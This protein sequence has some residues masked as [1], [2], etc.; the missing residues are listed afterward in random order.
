[1]AVNTIPF[2]FYFCHYSILY[3][4]VLWGIAFFAWFFM[5][6]I[7]GESIA[8]MMLKANTRLRLE[9]RNR[10]ST[11]FSYAYTTAK[12]E[13][14]IIS[15][16]VQL[17]IYEATIID[18]Y[19][20]GRNSLCLSSAALNLSE[21][22]LIT[23]CLMKFAQFAHHDSEILA[24]LTAGNIWYIIMAVFCKGVICFWGIIIAIIFFCMGKGMYGVI[25]HNVIRAMAKKTEQIILLFVRIVLRTGMK[26]Y[27]N[28]VYTNDEFVCN[29]GYKSQLINYLRDIEP[30]I[31]VQDSLFGTVEAMKPS[32]QLRLLKIENYTV[33]ES[34]DGGGFRIIRR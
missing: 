16:N 32:K 29:C 23:L 25:F 19:A 11:A 34:S 31:N 15:N 9:E 8:R 27:E 22:E 30:E 26:S 33:P 24:V 3:A 6:M 17:Y 18:G 20:I 14:P 2:Y 13:N 12:R 1:M 4:L 28:N 7:A 21:Q 5:V 10:V